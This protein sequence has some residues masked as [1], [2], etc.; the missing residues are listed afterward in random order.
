M[1][2]TEINHHKW[3]GGREGRISRHIDSLENVTLLNVQ[4][5]EKRQNVKIKSF[6]KGNFYIPL[7]Q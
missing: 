3:G 4:S 6:I 7:T 2:T 1:T 5:N